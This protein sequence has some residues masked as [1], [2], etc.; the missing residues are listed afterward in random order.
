MSVIALFYTTEAFLFEL[1][2]SHE[3]SIKEGN[4]KNEQYALQHYYLK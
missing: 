4:C 1:G 3:K 2:G